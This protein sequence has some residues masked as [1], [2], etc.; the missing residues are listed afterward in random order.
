MAYFDYENEQK[1]YK[2]FSITKENIIKNK[3]KTVCVLKRCDYDPRRGWMFPRY[4][5][6]H[7]TRYSQVI[8]DNGNNSFDKRDVLE[9]AI[10]E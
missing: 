3:G 1:G 7:D 2:P 5:I 8:I 9:I 10:K 4:Y 6:L